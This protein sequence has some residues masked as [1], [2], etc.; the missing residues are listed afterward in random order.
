M[1]FIRNPVVIAAIAALLAV[2]AIAANDTLLNLQKAYNAEL[3][4]RAVYLAFAQ[5]A[6]EEDYGAVAS[7]FRAVALA[8]ESQANMHAKL[9]KT[10]N[11]EP[12]ADLAVPVVGSTAENLIAASKTEKDELST[13]YGPFVKT[14]RHEKRMES[15]QSFRRAEKAEQEHAKLFATAAGSLDTLKGSEPVTYYVCPI[16][17]HVTQTMPDKHCPDCKHDAADYLTVR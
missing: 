8:E 11:V 7:L 17:G 5:K 2:P 1:K 13:M 6:T 4:T 16:C 9:I 12:K 14:A 15:L 3:N 10:F